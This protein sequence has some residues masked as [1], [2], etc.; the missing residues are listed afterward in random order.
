MPAATLAS[1]PSLTARSSE[2]SCTAGWTSTIHIRLAAAR[3]TMPA[4]VI[5]AQSRAAVLRRT[6]TESATAAAAEPTS[7]STS[8]ADGKSALFP[9]SDVTTDAA[10]P[11][12][13]DATEA[14]IRC[15]GS[16]SGGRLT[17]RPT[18]TAAVA[19][20]A[21]TNDHTPTDVTSSRRNPNGGRESTPKT[22]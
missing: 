6:K 4:S 5:V 16:R 21:T 8:A 10:A 2:G 13:T 14:A 19:A 9:S 15:Q 20:P 7:G 18:R 3:V 17:R 1:T 22:R 12:A 11:A